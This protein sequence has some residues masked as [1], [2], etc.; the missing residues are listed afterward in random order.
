MK[1]RP[2]D[3]G[4]GRCEFEFVFVNVA[5]GSWIGQEGITVVTSSGN[6]LGLCLQGRTLYLKILKFMSVQ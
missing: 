4:K 3:F 6:G 1:Y 2:Q 5:C